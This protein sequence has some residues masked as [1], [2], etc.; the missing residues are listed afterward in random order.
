MHDFVFISLSG[1]LFGK[2]WF[3]K[4]IVYIKTDTFQRY[5]KFLLYPNLLFH[6]N[7]QMMMRNVVFHVFGIFF[8]LFT[9][10][11]MFNACTC[12]CCV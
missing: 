3:S 9:L 5:M 2:S 11:L 8:F 7:D 10:L 1:W 12:I 4:G 6:H